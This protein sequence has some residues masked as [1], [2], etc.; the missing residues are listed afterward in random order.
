MTRLGQSGFDLRCDWG[1]DGLR[2]ILPGC[3]AVII[4]DVL[5]FCTTV[6]IAV[7]VG[8]AVYPAATESEGE[9]VAAREGATL[10]RSRSAGGLSLSPAP[11]LRLLPGERIVL[12]SPNG[13]RISLETG[14]I[15]TFAGCLRNAEAVAYGASRIARRI[16]VIAAGERWPGGRLRPA[17][18]DWL[19]AGAILLH[20]EGRRS[21]EAD[22][23]VAAFRAAE[24]DLDAA[25]VACGSGRELIERGHAADVEIAARYRS[26][27]AV[28][29]MVDG[30]FT[31]VAT[32]RAKE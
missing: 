32:Q 7:A 16:G 9:E 11:M 27:R 28:P 25:L 21:P 31:N 14:E 15:P 13:S 5:S 8:A 12:P 29:R 4:V 20:L 23:A 26:S 30:A 6:D 17:V 18:E 22:A 1:S 19:G 3:E 24:A 10:A 2:A